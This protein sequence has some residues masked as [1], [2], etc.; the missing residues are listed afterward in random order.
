M[1]SVFE[2]IG[3]G[4]GS[5]RSLLSHASVSLP[6][7]RIEYLSQIYSKQQLRHMRQLEDL[8]RQNLAS[9]DAFH[10]EAPWSLGHI[11]WRP[12]PSC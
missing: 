8:D 11:D 12:P 3:C 2:H 4:L 5:Y 1:L 6:V 9:T 7:G 10:L